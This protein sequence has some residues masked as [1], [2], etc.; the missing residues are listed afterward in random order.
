MQRIIGWF[1]TDRHAAAIRESGRDLDRIDWLRCSV[2]LLLHAAALGVFVVGWSWT[3][4]L[5]AVGL[6]AVR[7]FG[8][9]GFYHRY[10]SHRSYRTSRWAQFAF[11]VV[12]SSAAQR[13][14]LWWASIHR[15]HHRASDLENDPHSP[16]YRGLLH[17]HVRWFMSSR[18]YETNY[19]RVHDLARFPELV[20]LN[21]FD[22]AV[23]A[24]LALAVWLCGLALERRAPALG[25]TAAQFFIWGFVVSTLMV[26]HATSSIN[27][28]GHRF[29]SQRYATN[30]SSR[31]N[32]LLALL[33]LGE[34]WHN[35]HHR[36]MS[37]ARAGLTWWEIDPTYY[38]LKVLSWLGII[39]DLKQ[40]PADA[41]DPAVRRT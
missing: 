17:A 34:G 31:N 35:N 27:S 8:I 9:A 11:A 38:A 37:A 20:W 12:G 33:I 15:Q 2:F 19:R 16:V 30:D 6:Y 21:R 26:F 41:Y 29:G 18:H 5:A 32:P 13:G 23:P 4:L 10:F 28:F 24:A 3:S 22:T 40:A 36:Y 1:D 7:M 14:P 39:W 25:V